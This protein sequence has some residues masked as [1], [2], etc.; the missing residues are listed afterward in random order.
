M[1]IFHTANGRRIRKGDAVNH[2]GSRGYIV[3]PWGPNH[4]GA[5]AIVE[6]VD[7][8]RSRLLCSE[9]GCYHSSAD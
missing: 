2:K 7:G 4:K 5:G 1:P 6:W 9:I 8:S 3:E